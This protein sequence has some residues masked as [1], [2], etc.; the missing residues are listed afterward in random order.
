MILFAPPYPTEQDQAMA[1]RALI[2]ME[3]KRT[4]REQNLTYADVARKLEL[5]L[6]TVK[7]LF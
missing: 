4:L 3:L 1:E 2:V 6:A 5:S 7:R